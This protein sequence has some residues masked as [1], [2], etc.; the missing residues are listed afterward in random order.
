MKRWIFLF[1]MA[2]VCFQAAAQSDAN[3]DAE[4]Q[5]LDKAT[6]A[7]R[8]AFEKGDAA[9]VAQLH[10]PDI[11]KYFGGANV[12]VGREALEKGLRDWFRSSRV[13]FIENKVESTAFVGRT[14][15]QTV[16]F[17]IKSTP[18]NGGTPTIS[19]GRSMVIYVRDEHSPTGWVS[20]REMTQ[21]APKPQ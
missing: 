6:A 7:I 11:E 13:E 5:S 21:E 9:L 20:L 17:A 14:A 12:V 18:K 19:R 3:S 16:I 10:S 4:R 15:V 8:S 2:A 1:V